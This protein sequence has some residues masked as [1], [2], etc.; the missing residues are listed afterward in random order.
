[1][2]I[3]NDL[4]TDVATIRDRM[5]A[6]RLE[7]DTLESA[8]LPQH[9]AEAKAARYV[10]HLAAEIAPSVA[11]FIRRAQVPSLDLGAQEWSAPDRLAA[12]ACWLDPAAVTAKLHAEIAA[13]YS[14]HA[15][16]LTDADVRKRSAEIADEMRA[17]GITEERAI[18]DA[19]ACGITIL[20]RADADPAALIAAA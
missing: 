2:K 5:T 1:M 20:R 11:P 3:K 12:F 9:E 17:L 6:L 19:A 16:G 15:P 4:R 14:D 7:R 18:L 8:P 10:A 13:L